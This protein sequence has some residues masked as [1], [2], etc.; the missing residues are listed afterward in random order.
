VPLISIFSGDFFDDFSVE[1]AK[2]SLANSVP[3]FDFSGNFAIDNTKKDS[4][5]S[6]TKIDYFYVF[7]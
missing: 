1:H 3:L 2:N 4:E 5:S 6:L 7:Y